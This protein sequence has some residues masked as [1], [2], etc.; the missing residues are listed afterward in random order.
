MVA[1]SFELSFHE[2]QRFY[3]PPP[4]LPFS[5]AGTFVSPQ[6]GGT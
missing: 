2:G 3:A 1:R 6:W 5:A 4:A